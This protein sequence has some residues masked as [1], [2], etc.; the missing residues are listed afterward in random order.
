MDMENVGGETTE[1]MCGHIAIWSPGRILDVNGTRVPDA[2]GFVMNFIDWTKLKDRSDIYERFSM[3]NLEFE[4]I[5]KG[6]SVLGMDSVMLAHSP[7]HELLTDDNSVVVETSSLH[8]VWQNTVGPIDGWEPSWYTPSICLVVLV[9]VLIGFLVASTLV[10][11]QL[12]RNLLSNIM[13]P[14]AIRKLQRNQT[15]LGKSHWILTESVAML[16]P[17]P[18]HC[19]I[20]L[21]SPNLQRSTNRSQSSSVIS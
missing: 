14:Q 19:C 15:V 21:P 7:D 3:S 2:W 11:R 17:L 9:S 5:R 4:L 13:P 10:E 8:G 1:L 16:D 6:G 20:F 18:A 12:H